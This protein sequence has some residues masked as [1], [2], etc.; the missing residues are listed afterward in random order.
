ME[1][2][3]EPF[4]MTRTRLE[5]F[6]DGVLAIAIT[7]MV[8]ELRA[9]HHAEWTALVDLVPTFVGYVLSF[10]YIAIYWTN[11]HHMFH[12]VSRVNGRILWAN[13]HL[14][15]WLSLIPFASAW[16]DETGFAGPP[17][18]LYG[19]ILLMAAI[20]YYALSRVIIR[21]QAHG[22]R[23]A[24]EAA[25]GHD[26]KGKVSIVIYVVAI[27][28]SF[29]NRWIAVTLYALVAAMWFIP[30]RRIERRADSHGA[31]VGSVGAG[32]GSVG[33]GSGGG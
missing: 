1:T 15:F 25:I 13:L 20:A 3:G 24:L 9:P 8:L 6:S 7:I 23:H 5:A 2:T 11:H 33:A 21:S 22:E 10:I 14:L 32:T 17:V 26:W 28:L 30:D 12:T 16:M 27:A 4:V 31:G 29:E 19:V 18:A